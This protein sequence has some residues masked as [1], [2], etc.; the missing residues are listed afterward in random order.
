MQIAIG[1]KGYRRLE[2]IQPDTDSNRSAVKDYG[3]LEMILSAISNA[4]DRSEAGY[5][6]G[7]NFFLIH[8]YL[9]NFIRES[10]GRES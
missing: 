1:W 8:V 3:R 10:Y 9:A 6:D 7:Y 2:R 5:Y 4:N